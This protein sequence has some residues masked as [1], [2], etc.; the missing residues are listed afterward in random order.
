MNWLCKLLGIK[1][2]VETIIVEKQT[3]PSLNTYNCSDNQKFIKLNWNKYP[4]CVKEYITNYYKIDDIERKYSASTY[5]IEFYTEK[6]S[7][8]IRIVNDASDV[9]IATDGLTLVIARYNGVIT[10]ANEKIKALPDVSVL[11]KR[12]N[13]LMEIAKEEGW[14]CQFGSGGMHWGKTGVLDDGFGSYDIEK[15]NPRTEIL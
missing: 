1:K 5:D 10:A 4:E 11:R 7:D 2:E 13:E 9:G 3:P 6:I 12:N 14:I 15:R 8:S